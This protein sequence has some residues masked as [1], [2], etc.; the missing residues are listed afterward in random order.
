MTTPAA[1][2]RRVLVASD[3]RETL[4]DA[5]EKAATIEHYTGA[6]IEAALVIYDPIA[7]EPE[8]H[9]TR[10]ETR[11]IVDKIKKTELADLEAQLAPFK[12]RI[13]DLTASILFERDVA[14]AIATAAGAFNADLILKPLTRSARITDLLHAPADW[15]LMRDAPAPVLFT[16]HMPWPKSV[17]VLAAL[18]A[19]DARHE[20]L[21]REILRHAYLLAQV[22]GGEMHV[23]SSYPSL[24]QQ[25]SEYQVAGD[26]DAIKRDMRARREAGITTLLDDL[27]VTAAGVHVVEGR[28]R[29]VISELA[30]RIGAGLTVLGTAARRGI[31]K[32]LIGNTAEDITRELATDLLTVRTRT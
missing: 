4:L 16:R 24:G 7:E 8:G 22:L 25:M 12:K 15:R 32:L 18:D 11:R 29:H 9:F 6:A 3:T 10:A 19:S 14:K 20:G 26:F 17:R 1:G 23:V 30:T 21:N 2:V 27:H 28:P 31:K 5:L 13:A